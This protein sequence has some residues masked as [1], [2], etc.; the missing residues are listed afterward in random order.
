MLHSISVYVEWSLK[1][2]IGKHYWRVMP[3]DA[4]LRVHSNLRQDAELHIIY[5][6]LHDKVGFSL[7]SSHK[8]IQYG[9]MSN[10]FGVSAQ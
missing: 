3:K 4:A 8:T 5:I 2:K 6:C 10:V 7:L 9:E 1:Y